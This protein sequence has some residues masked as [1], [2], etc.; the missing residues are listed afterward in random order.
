MPRLV[1]IAIVLA[2][3]APAMAQE[4]E[5][6]PKFTPD[7]VK[8]RTWL[9]N[10]RMTP[11]QFRCLDRLWMNESSWRVKAK[12]RY[13]GAYG[14]PQ[15]LP[16]KKMRSAG[17][18]WRWNAKTQVRWGLRYIGSRYGTACKALAYQNARGWY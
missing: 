14:I 5:A 15:A 12:N 6:K 17:K 16:G 10:H 4:V 8:V 13:S 3:L 1:I 18:D 9:K 7:V 2:L 11:R